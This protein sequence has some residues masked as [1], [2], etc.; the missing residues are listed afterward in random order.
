MDKIVYRG[1][2]PRETE[3]FGKA[4]EENH[5]AGFEYYNNQSTHV[6]I[7]LFIVLVIVLLSILYMIHLFG[8]Y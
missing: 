1:Q 8:L 4:S 3:S 5:K 6:S 7:M 2:M